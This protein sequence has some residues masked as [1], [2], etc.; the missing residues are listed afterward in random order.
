MLGVFLVVVLVERKKQI[1]FFK[2]R[3]KKHTWD[4]LNLHLLIV[5]WLLIMHLGFVFLIQRVPQEIGL[6]EIGPNAGWLQN[7]TPEMHELSTWFFDISLIILVVVMLYE[8]FKM[9]YNFQNK[10]WPR[11]SFYMVFITI[12]MGLL[13]LLV[14]ELTYGFNIKNILDLI[15]S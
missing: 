3:L 13:G 14:Q 7:Y 12:A 6:L 2:E 1:Y 4:F 11:W 15:G 9:G 5:S 10:P 8:Q